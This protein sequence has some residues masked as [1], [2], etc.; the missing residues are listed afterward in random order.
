MSR[1]GADARPASTAYI[2][3]DAQFFEQPGPFPVEPGT[4]R[5][6]GHV[7]HHRRRGSGAVEQGPGW[8]DIVEAIAWAV[9][10]AELVVVR[11]GYDDVHV[12]GREPR[13]GE[14]AWPP[15]A[16]IE[17]VRHGTVPLPLGSMEP[18]PDVQPVERLV[19]RS[20][21]ASVHGVSPRRVVREDGRT[22]YRWRISGRPGVIRLAFASF[23]RDGRR[24]QQIRAWDEDGTWHEISIP[25]HAEV[26]AIDRGPV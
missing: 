20:W 14:L 8:D 3:E 17:A 13:A 12:I 21:L 15:A 25:G 23:L 5:F 9:P 24:W 6:Y 22:R 2:A 16:G 11:L 26:V 4:P 10:R 19:L 7:E 18:N 1:P